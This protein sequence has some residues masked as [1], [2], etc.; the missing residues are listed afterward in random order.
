MSEPGVGDEVA[1][2]AKHG[3]VPG[4]GSGAHVV[5]PP[6]PFIVPETFDKVQKALHHLPEAS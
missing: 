3:A 6:R 2:T 5:S 4:T 1:A